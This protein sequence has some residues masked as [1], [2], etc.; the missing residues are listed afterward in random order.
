MLRCYSRSF[1]KDGI[2]VNPESLIWCVEQLVYFFA[3]DNIFLTT[4][5]HRVHLPWQL[6]HSSPARHPSA[7]RGRGSAPA[8]LPRRR[9]KPLPPTSS[10]FSGGPVWFCRFIKNRSIEFE[11]FKNLRNFKIKNSKKASLNLK[12]F[13]QNRI[14]NSSFSS[15]KIRARFDCC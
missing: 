3:T 10:M 8:T 4:F 13:S 9:S 11:I 12:N 2:V 5:F 6:R 7:A 15:W 1:E 14:K